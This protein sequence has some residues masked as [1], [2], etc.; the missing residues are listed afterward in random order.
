MKIEKLFLSLLVL[1]IASFVISI[2]LWKTKT[3]D[4]HLHDTYFVISCS[5]I[6]IICSFAA[7]VNFTL[8][9]IIG[10]KD[11][12]L[13]YWILVLHIIMFVVFLFLISGL[14]FTVRYIEYTQ[15][16]LPGWSL[17]AFVLS[18]LLM[19]VY[20]FLPRRKISA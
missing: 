5:Q 13:N 1:L 8:Y 12:S 14:G 19:A 20:C 4:I 18:E 9:K 10:H 17:I 6:V 7:L 11:G 2:T 16:S 3:I 15:S